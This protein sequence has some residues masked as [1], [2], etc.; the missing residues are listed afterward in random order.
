MRQ[1]KCIAL[2]GQNMLVTLLLRQS[3]AYGFGLCTCKCGSCSGKWKCS[4]A[5]T[6]YLRGVLQWGTVCWESRRSRSTRAEQMVDLE[7][8]A[9]S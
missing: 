2:W 3:G 1:R 5:A 6:L 8:A 9:F 4:I 7:E